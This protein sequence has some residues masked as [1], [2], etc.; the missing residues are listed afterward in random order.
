MVVLA[1][2]ITASPVFAWDANAVRLATSNAIQTLPPEME[3]FFEAGR[4]EIV[5]HSTDPLDWLSKDPHEMPHHFIQ[6]DYYGRFPF[7]A[8]PRDYK[9]AV[10]KYGRHKIEAHGLLPWQIGVYS[11]RLTTAFHEHR[12]SQA[13]QMAA[14]L[15]AYV[16]E[17]HDPFNTTESLLGRNVGQAGISERF[18]TSLVDRYLRFLFISPADATFIK[19]PTD[20][21][22]EM[23]LSAHGHIEQVLL[24]DRRAHHGLSGYS[25][26]YYDRFYARA[27]LVVLR[28]LTD[29]A[30]DIGSYWYTAWVNAGHPALPEH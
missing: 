26:E 30:T 1:V 20:Y 24:A 2:L 23:C 7:D 21:A 25:D 27:G 4:G 19:D 10:R 15:A 22:F 13:R 14:I 12:W 5:A 29:A 18:G 11:E 17:A 16:T 28:E 6:L 9:A 3:A 8:L